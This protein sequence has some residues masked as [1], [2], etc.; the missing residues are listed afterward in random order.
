MIKTALFFDI[1]GTLVENGSLMQSAFQQGFA[2]Q[3]LAIEIDP[4]KGSGC[5]DWQI[6]DMFLADFPQLSD[7]EREALKEKIAP[8][9]QSI[10]IEKVNKT[11]LNALP[12]T[13]ELIQRLVKLGCTPGLL[14]GNMQNIVRPKLKAAGFNPDDFKYGGFGDYC[15]HRVDTAKKA[16]QS[17]SEF[18]KCTIAP[19][20]ALII[21]DTP[22]DIACAKAVGVPVLAVA[23]GKYSMEELASHDPDFLLE[24]LTDWVK[25]LEIIDY[26]W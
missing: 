9:V 1:D 10:V 12:G 22:N 17:A 24:D 14:T 3:G 26:P 19:D 13:Q 20:E 25:F 2:N 6:L 4:W 11:G 21:G 7:K 18:L 5:T 15:P 8:D 23:S 16:L